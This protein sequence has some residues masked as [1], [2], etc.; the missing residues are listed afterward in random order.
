MMGLQGTDWK[1]NKDNLLEA[2]YRSGVKVYIPS[3]FGTNHYIT[4]YTDNKTFA[5]KAHHFEEAKEKIPKV[6]G[7]FTS[8]MM[9]QAFF[10]WLGFDNAKEEWRIVGDGDV[11]VSLTARE[12]VGRFTVETSIMAFQEPEKVPE[13]VVIDSCTHTLQE[14]AAILDKYATTGN[15]IKII[16]T[17]LKDAKADWELKKASIP[18]GMVFSSHFNY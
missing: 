12:D 14:Y 17:P 10:K 7:I 1:Q 11:P 15:K 16:G 3:E 8:L 2:C 18:D 5:P 13:S 9:E 6:I 4:N